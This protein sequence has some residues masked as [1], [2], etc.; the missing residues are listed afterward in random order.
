MINLQS[1]L[2]LQPKIK[3]KSLQKL[4]PVQMA[5]ARET[6]LEK[7]CQNDGV[8]PSYVLAFKKGG[9]TKKVPGKV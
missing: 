7:L 9:E 1:L 8:A 2:L 5:T 3:I 6:K 4:L